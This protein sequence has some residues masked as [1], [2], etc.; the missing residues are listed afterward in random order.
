MKF[1]TN[2]KLNYSIFVIIAASIVFSTSLYVYADNFSS[3]SM[4]AETDGANSFTEL[5]GARGVDTFVIGSSTY[6]I[7]VSEVDDGIQI[8]DISDPT[9]LVA[10]DAETDGANSCLLYT[11][12]SP[13]DRQ[14]SRMPS[15]A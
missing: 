10:K 11:S 9:A 15:S 1:M 3:F 6:A 14:K 12:P 8:V 2:R 4:D 13:R 5:E 7:V